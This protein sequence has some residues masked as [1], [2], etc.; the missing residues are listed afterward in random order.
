MDGGDLDLHRLLLEALRTCRRRLEAQLPLVPGCGCV[1]AASC[2]GL[3]GGD[4]YS[5]ARQRGLGVQPDVLAVDFD[6]PPLLQHGGT[7][8]VAGGLLQAAG[9][10]SGCRLHNG[11]LHETAVWQPFG[12]CARRAHNGLE[13]VKFFR[14]AVVAVGA[15]GALRFG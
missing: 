12:R 5:G 9:Q 14:N 2:G 3:T 7:G 15:D 13:V 4:F 1:S 11:G 6:L 8:L 10:V